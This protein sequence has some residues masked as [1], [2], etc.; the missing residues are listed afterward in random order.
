[1]DFRKALMTSIATAF[2]T[3]RLGDA[4]FAAIRFPFAIHRGLPWVPIGA[5]ALFK[6]LEHASGA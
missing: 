4:D 6:D 3:S 1:M 2:H 5:A